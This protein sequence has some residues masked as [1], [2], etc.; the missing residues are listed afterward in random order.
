MKTR[1]SAFEDWKLI[2][3]ALAWVWEKKYSYTPMEL[4]KLLSEGTIK[5]YNEHRLQAVHPKIYFHIN[6]QRQA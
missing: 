2:N 1:L 3:N 5:I 4:Q 6:T